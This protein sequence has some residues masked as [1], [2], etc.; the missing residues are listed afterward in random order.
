LALKV[1]PI[2]LRP[3]RWKW[4]LGLAAGPAFWPLP[5]LAIQTH[6]HPEGLYAHQMGHVV[7]L[8]AMIY[9]C[10]EIWRRQLS[11]RPGFRR[12]F[13]ACLLFGAWNV[14]TFWGHWAEEGLDSGAIDRQAGYLFRHL[15][16]TD[17]GGLIYYLAS[18]DHLI[19]IPAL[20]LFYA[21]LR[22]FLA[23]QQA[24]ARE[25]P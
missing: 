17:L 3:S 14:L 11:D 25:K 15:H 21:G 2:R 12:L 10:W 5:A 18:L 16:I 9:V 19:L 13:W 7:F 8:G 23:E 22:A 6:G 24:E 20:W 4:R 1:R